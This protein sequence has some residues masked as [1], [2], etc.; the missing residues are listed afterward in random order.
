MSDRWIGW[1]LCIVVSFS[2]S[3][4]ED[5]QPVVSRVLFGSCI[6]QNLP[7]PIFERMIDADPGLLILLG[8]NIYADTSDMLEMK[9]KYDEL[10][11]MPHF[12][13]LRRRC[14][15]LAT[16]DDHDFGINDG[17]ADFPEREAAE[18]VFLNFWNDPPDSP[19]RQRP[20]VYEARVFGPPGKRLQVILLD[21]R[22]FRSPLLKGKKRIGGPYVPDPDPNKTMLGETQWRWLEE[23]LRAPADVRIIASSIQFVAEA[24]GQE[25]WSNLPKERQR[26]I[27]TI[28]RT[29]ANGVLFISGDRHWSEVSA[30]REEAPYVLYDITSSSLNQNHPRGTPTV[31]RYRISETTCHVPNF[32]VLEI[33]WQTA[34][35]TLNAK[36]IRE[37]DKVAIKLK[38]EVKDLQQQD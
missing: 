8:D 2:T 31:N 1:L 36:I 28:R 7:A 12:A 26:M 5:A 24:A 29:S 3:S 30:M 35:P 14:P 18:Q 38:I 23:Q 32:G 21:T 25:C 34:S 20:G 37:D 15:V 19:R 33:D 11:S 16:W 9:H 13:E 22:Y 6:K 17:G 4:A 27:D 10:S